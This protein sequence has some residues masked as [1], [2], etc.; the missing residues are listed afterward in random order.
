[1]RTQGDA[2]PGPGSRIAVIGAGLAGLVSAG[3]L[4]QRYR[5]TLFEAAADLCRRTVDV[6]LDGQT[7]A[8]DAGLSRFSMTASPNLTALLDVLGAGTMGCP[9]TLGV[10]FDAGRHEWA[11]TG[12][13]TLF[14]QRR[15]LLSPGFF[16]LLADARHFRRHA[17][18]LR[19]DAIVTRFTMV[20]LLA[21]TRYGRA[22]RDGYL[23]PV[24]A[25]IW[26][27]PAID[28][29]NMP[30][31]MFL[32]VFVTHGLQRGFGRPVWRSVYGGGRSWLPKLAGQVG[33]LR[34][35][36]PV[37]AIRR[38]PL[39][40]LVETPHCVERFDA[41]IMAA[42]APVTRSLLADADPDETAVLDVLR[43]RGG[44]VWLHADR[45]LLPRRRKAWAVSN[46]LCRSAA[47]SSVCL[48]DR[49][50]LLQ[51]LTLKTPLL[52]TV[53]PL[54]EPDSPFL[55]FERQFPVF[56]HDA[57]LAQARL[58]QLQGH[59]ASWYAGAWTG[60]GLPES[61]VTSALAIAADFGV[62]PAWER[63]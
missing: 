1:M 22:F 44:S 63:R 13:D 5:V 61:A 12:I 35:A 37:I 46:Y 9:A 10:S 7:W 8:V 48:S 14:A 20:Q 25:M 39:G 26:S 49:L 15:N 62:S 2:V 55:R 33:E 17:E 43:C 38:E 4:S 59:R 52:L 24:A 32:R 58:A 29:L 16:G 47:V 60:D 31:T 11:D 19:L 36:T 54:I 56:D 3:L 57:T 40:V 21:R 30:A 42:K 41:V 23:L 45:R 34:M 18:E 27:D 50:D 53:D 28:V 51:H 6:T